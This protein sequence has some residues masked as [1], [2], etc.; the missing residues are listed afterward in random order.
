MARL[1]GAV[2]SYQMPN[3]KIGFSFPAERLY[4]IHDQPR[5]KYVPEILIDPMTEFMKKDTDIFISRALS[6]LK[7]KR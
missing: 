1:N 2:Y 4:T 5:E 7:N 6:Y 3:S